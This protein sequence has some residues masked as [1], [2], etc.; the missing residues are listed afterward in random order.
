MLEVT[1]YLDAWVAINYAHF[2]LPEP[3]DFQL[4]IFDSYTE[5]L[6]VFVL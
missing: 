2:M 5:L 1:I 6:S 4:C 3:I